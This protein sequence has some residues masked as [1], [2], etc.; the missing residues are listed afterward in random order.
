M[1]GFKIAPLLAA[2]GL[3]NIGVE[4]AKNR[5]T[6]PLLEPSEVAIE[7]LIDIG[8]KAAKEGLIDT[9]IRAVEGVKDIFRELRGCPTIRALSATNTT[10]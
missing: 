7:G 10:F 2:K 1:R 8:T 5:L 6:S 3:E 9:P 4:A